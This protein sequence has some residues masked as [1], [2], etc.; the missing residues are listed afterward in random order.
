[1]NLENKWRIKI[2]VFKL[3]SFYLAPSSVEIKDWFIAILN[4][5]LIVFK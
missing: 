4:E 1:M 2:L 3:F 5:L